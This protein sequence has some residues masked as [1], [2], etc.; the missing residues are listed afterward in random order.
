M[1]LFVSFCN[2]LRGFILS[3]VSAYAKLKTRKISSKIAR[4]PHFLPVLVY[5]ASS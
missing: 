2:L 4:N 1:S 3:M 5:T